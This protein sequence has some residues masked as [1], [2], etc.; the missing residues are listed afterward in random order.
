MR[1]C[2]V[3]CLAFAAAILGSSPA[4][5]ASGDWVQWHFL[6]S[7]RIAADT[8]GVR[9]QAV[10]AQPTSQVLIQRAVAGLS[11]NVSSDAGSAEQVRGWLG[12]GFRVESYGVVRDEAGTDRPEWLVA[13][14]LGHAQA[15][16]W[17]GRW[18]AFGKGAGFAGARAV[19]ADDWFLGGLRQ[20]GAVDLDPLRQ[21]LTAAPASDQPTPWLELELDLARLS[22]AFGWPTAIAWP[23]AHVTLTGRGL[24]VR[25][26]AELN[27]PAPLKLRL[28]E[29]DIPTK[30]VHDPLQSFTALQGIQPWLSAQASLQELGWPIP[31]QVFAWSQSVAPYATHLA[32][33]MPEA[34]TRIPAAKDKLKPVLVGLAPWSNL[35]EVEVMPEAHRLN[36]RGFPVLVPFVA[37]AEDDGFALAG[38]FPLA[39]P[40]GSA[41]PELFA[42]LSGRTN[43]VYYHW[44]LTQPRLDD[45][46]Q[47]DV[48]YT[49]IGGFMPP[50]S[51]SVA[52]AWM[53]DTNVTSQL[54]NSV[55]EL[56][57][58]SPT[59]LKAVRN[60]AVGLTAFELFRTALW[61]EGERFPRHTP[62]QPV[63]F[64]RKSPKPPA[65]AAP[66]PASPHAE[67][68][69]QH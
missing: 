47:L 46:Q 13:L 5:G 1:A 45:W 68:R 33:R 69:R 61:I 52:R 32:W 35:G 18:E 53:R 49:I 19:V 51:N 24:D 62:P 36:W 67:T 65:T 44:E 64:S 57:A 9:A 43:L 21:R 2:F 12:D 37:P 4:V 15:Q 17:A 11:R 6:G 42:Q 39:N 34:D 63:H 50:P 16:E 3:G 26:T 27:F 28:A 30:T 54:G 40:G 7:T 31:N 20:T 60:S 8:N 38:I 25:T 59:Q 56:T 48:M 66:T 22:R 10:L 23:Q 55:T 14:R 41:P 58:A 29:W